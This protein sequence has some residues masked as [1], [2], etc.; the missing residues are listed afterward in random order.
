MKPPFSEFPSDAETLR[1][2][3]GLNPTGIRRTKHGFGV[4]FAVPGIADIPAAT[5]ES[6]AA[7]S[8]TDCKS[9]AGKLGAIARIQK[10]AA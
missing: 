7:P 5:D 4:F 2:A 1:W 9:R 6:I 3:C 8:P 10:G